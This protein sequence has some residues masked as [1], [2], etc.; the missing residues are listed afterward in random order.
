MPRPFFDCGFKL[1]NIHTNWKHVSDKCQDPSSILASHCA[2][3]TEIGNMH[4]TNVR[5][6][7]RFWLQIVQHSRELEICT[8]QTSRPFFGLDFKLCNTPTDWEHASGKC[9]NHSSTL[10]SN[11]ATLPQIGNMHLA[12]VM[13]ILRFWLQIVQHSHKWETRTWQMP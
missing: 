1:C 11:C 9:Q 12:N 7:L 10:T 13:T 6:L 2:T 5:T 4:L 3:L 8:W